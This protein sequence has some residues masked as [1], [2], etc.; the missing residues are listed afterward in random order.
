MERIR[1]TLFLLVLLLLSSS[2]AA[3]TVEIKMSQCPKPFTDNIRQM[4]AGL[5]SNDQVI[6]NFDKSGTYEFDGSIKIRCNTI[7]KGIST[8]NTRVIV[9]EGFANGKS[10][11]LDDTFFAMHGSSNKKIKVEIKDIAFLLANHKGILW[12]KAPKHM[13][14]IYYGD[15]IVVDNIEMLSDN[16][17]IT[18][19][20]LR[21][22]SN[23]LVQNSTFENFN[24]CMLG[25]CLWSRGYQKNIV[26]KNNKFLKYGNDE[27]LAIWS[28][29]DKKAQLIKNIIVDGNEF[30][31]ENKKKSKN[32]YNIDVIINFAHYKDELVNHTCTVSNIVFNNNTITNNAQTKRSIWF[33]F[34]DTAILDTIE[35]TNNTIRNSSKCQISDGY[36]TDIIIDTGSK[37][38]GDILISGN[39]VYNEAEIL[40]DGKNSGYTFLGVKNGYV[41]LSNNN[42][43][44]NYPVAL[45]WSHGGYVSLN[46]NDNTASMLYKTAILN[47]SDNL[48]KIVI[49]ANNNE[50][51]GDTRIYCN[52]IEELELNFTNNTFN[53]NDYHFFIQEGAATTSIIF[54]G[55]TVNALTGKGT[56]FANYSGNPCNFK[57]IR[58]SNNLFRGISKNDVENAFI[59]TSRKSISNNI[60]R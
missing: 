46:L 43:Q 34:D 55:N 25:G 5:N 19:L 51:T 50:F 59:R 23:V 42:I 33:H 22:C 47:S 57:S 28:S 21:N 44:S 36:L 1:Y 30:I 3:R 8:K 13:I 58:I 54:D 39:N 20:D 24:N 2:V 53:S 48:D 41:N 37:N 12:E 16:A 15:G 17:A 10:K 38:R 32:N 52:N 40:C 29:D 18:N 45:V 14:K 56:M 27:P 49:N 60:Y 11:M 35:V 4:V 6:I 31:Y 9:K 7:I 26:I